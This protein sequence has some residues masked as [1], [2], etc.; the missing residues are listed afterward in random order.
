MLG[1]AAS[2]T[3]LR[4]PVRRAAQQ[5]LEFDVDGLPAVHYGEAVAFSRSNDSSRVPVKTRYD[6]EG[7]IEL[8]VQLGVYTPGWN[9][10][11]WIT[12]GDIDLRWRQK[13]HPSA[14]EIDVV[15]RRPHV[16]E[17]RRIPTMR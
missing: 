4:A 16:D 17:A 5:T 13:T 3:A 10:F 15:R 11:G 8:I 2:S 7:R 9:A 14:P 6:G 12:S 1:I